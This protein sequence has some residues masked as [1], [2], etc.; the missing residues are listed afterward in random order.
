MKIFLQM[1]KKR[2]NKSD[3]YAH[4]CSFNMYPQ[5][6]P[7]APILKIANFEEWLSWNLLSHREW[8]LWAINLII[9][10]LEALPPVQE[11]VAV[12]GSDI[13]LSAGRLDRP[14]QLFGQHHHHHHSLAWQGS[15]I[16]EWCILVDSMQSCAIWCFP[17][18]QCWHNM[19]C[20]ALN[21]IR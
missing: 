5:D 14:V 1:C 3:F 17:R 9:L 18:D 19:I 20:R 7:Y 4:W 8:Y 10:C 13:N 16:A 15:T 21:L 12:K 2:W 11:E 6:K